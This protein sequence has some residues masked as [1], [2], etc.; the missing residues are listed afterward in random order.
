MDLLPYDRHRAVDYAHRWAYGR[1]TVY[2]GYDE[3][4][5][6]CTNFVSQCLYAGTGVMNF[7]PDFGWYYLNP[8]NKAPAWTGV[9]YLRNFLLRG[10]R[11]PGP[12]A[13]EHRVLTMTQPGDIIQLQFGGDQYTH[14]LIVVSAEAATPEGIR[15]ASHSFDAD[16]RPLDSYAYLRYRLLHINGYYK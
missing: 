6:D 11:T 12:V 14:T 3:L 15:V 9:A 16:C 13:T 1:N 10:E 4:G 5:G 2:Y 7:T 8:D